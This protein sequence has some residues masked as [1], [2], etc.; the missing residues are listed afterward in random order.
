MVGRLA[1]PRQ[2]RRRSDVTNCLRY[3][4]GV[5]GNIFMASNSFEAKWLLCSLFV[6]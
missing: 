6:I 5:I 1:R 4:D 3:S 2:V